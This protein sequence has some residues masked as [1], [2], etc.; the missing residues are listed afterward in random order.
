MGRIDASLATPQR[1]ANR[2]D[3]PDAALRRL[4]LPAPADRRFLDIVQLGAADLQRAT[5]R[6]DLERDHAE[7]VNIQ[8]GTAYQALGD[9]EK[10]LQEIQKLTETNS[11]S[12]TSPFVRRDNQKQIDAL[13]E[14]VERI[15]QTTRVEELPLFDGKLTLTAGSQSIDLPHFSLDRLGKTFLNGRSLSLADL[16]SRQPL[17]T[18][19]R[20]SFTTLGSAR[21]VRDALKTVGTLREQLQTFSKEAVIPRLRDVAEVVAGLSQTVSFDTIGSSE[22]AMEVL[23][24]I[25]LMTL[26]ATGVAAAVGADGWNQQRVIELLS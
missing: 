24:E 18:T 5:R 1:P 22:Q 25:R 23:Q 4:D 20:T 17:D 3:A 13:L 2:Y 10:K 14:D 12:G 11:R 21:S 15:F 6:I 26:Q 7:R 16:K 9:V 8:T 19:R